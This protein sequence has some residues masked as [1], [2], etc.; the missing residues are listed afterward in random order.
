MHL[1]DGVQLHY[2]TVIVPFV[3]ALSSIITHS[4]VLAQVA[5]NF[6]VQE[7]P[8]ACTAKGSQELA[9]QQG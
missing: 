8:H 7:K 5:P 2:V 6:E 3:V 1:L 4:H 9:V